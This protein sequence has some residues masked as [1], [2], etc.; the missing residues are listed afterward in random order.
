[1]RIK[2]HEIR[3][4]RPVLVTAEARQKAPTII[5]TVEPE[6]EEKAD[7]NGNSPIRD[8]SSI[9][10]IVVTQSGN[11]SPTHQHTDRKVIPRIRI[12]RLPELPTE[13]AALF[14]VAGAGMMQNKIQTAIPAKIQTDFLGVHFFVSKIIPPLLQTYQLL[15]R[16]GIQKR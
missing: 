3:V 11:T 15:F 13:I 12:A 8:Q 4:K 16:V 5:H 10:A 6:K 9:I 14:R 1:M 7:E 2:N